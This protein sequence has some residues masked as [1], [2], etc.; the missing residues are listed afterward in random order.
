MRKKHLGIF[1]FFSFLF[2]FLM[3]NIVDDDGAGGGD[4]DIL[5][6]D[7]EDDKGEEKKDAGEKD[8]KPNEKKV[9]GIGDEDKALLDELKQERALNQITKEMKAQYGDS[10]DMDAI[11]AKLNE[12]EKE[13]PGSGQ[14]LF[15]KVGIENTFLKHFANKGSD[16]EFDGNGG[17]G[18]KQLSTDELIGKINSGE[19]SE[20]ERQAFFAKYA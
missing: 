9:E 10:F 14:A 1:T 15:N 17:R 6:K 11:T 12:M 2:S 19:A 18:P 8:P 16:D 7:L 13:K 5:D 20:T 3:T 4:D